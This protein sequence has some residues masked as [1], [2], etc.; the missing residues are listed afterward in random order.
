MKSN[1]SDTGDFDDHRFQIRLK[2]QRK[3]PSGGAETKAASS[4]FRAV[5]RVCSSSGAGSHGCFSG[6]KSSHRNQKGKGVFT[7]SAGQTAQ[8]VVV[9]TRV[10][11]HPAGGKSLRAFKLHLGYLTR[12]GVEREG[13]ERS[14]CYDENGEL[15]KQELDLWAEETARDRHHFRFIISPEKARELDLFRYSTELVK[16]MERDLGTG[17]DFV[18]V[19][20]YNTDNPHVHL[21]VRG[22]NDRGEDL[23]IGRD[24]IASGVRSRARELATSWLGH[25]SE[26]EIRDG[27]IAEIKLERLTGIDRELLYLQGRNPERTIDL[28]AP[29]GHENSIAGF[30]RSVRKQRL[31]ELERLELADEISPGVWRLSGETE[32]VLRELGIQR[33]IIKTMHRCLGRE[34]DR[35]LVIFDANDSQQQEVR[36]TVLDRG[37]SNELR[38]EKYLVISGADERA[39]YVGLSRF[40]ELDGLEASPG[41]RVR[42]S[43]QPHELEPRISDGNIL[44]LARD[45][46]GIYDRMR[47][48]ERTDPGRLPPGVTP[49]AYLEN[50]LK[51]LATLERNGLVQQLAQGAWRVPPDLLDRMHA[52]S[53]EKGLS[54]QVQV[55]LEAP[56]R[57]PE[58]A[59]ALERKPVPKLERTR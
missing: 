4:F 30:H 46:G 26:L 15:S 51:R 17:L 9:K 35:E 19:N 5:D 34:A 32:R 57:V 44:E 11:R 3:S 20:H 6:S 29:G 40:S 42:I 50:H 38:D 31:L 59:P 24:Y 23:V 21:I 25:R 8:R 28:R 22:K 27:M 7:R 33:D 43:A 10:V 56:A 37:V 45:N 58:L 55:R 53:K 1:S 39:Y 41:S 49:E 54:R 48:L 47:H 16:A 36:G 52:L 18:A 13:P 14:R 2:K 12:P